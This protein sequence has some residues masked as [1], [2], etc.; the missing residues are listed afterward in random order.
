MYWTFLLQQD[1][2]L[3][4]LATTQWHSW[5][6]SSVSSQ[7]ISTNQT[8]LQGSNGTPARAQC[9]IIA[10]LWE[11]PEGSRLCAAWYQQPPLAC[12]PSCGLGKVSWVPSGHFPSR[13]ASA[14]RKQQRKT[15]GWEHKST[16]FA[17]E[18]AGSVSVKL[19]VSTSALW[20]IKAGTLVFCLGFWIILKT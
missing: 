3:S 17:A 10:W 14:G 18:W 6:C 11:S 5:S 12:H 13:W 8:K 15:T 1:A 7:K 19:H 2:Q 20:E 9:K 4:A 16:R